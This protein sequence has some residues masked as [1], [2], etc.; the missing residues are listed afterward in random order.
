LTF[1]FGLFNVVVLFQALPYSEN[2]F[3]LPADA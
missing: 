2:S 3:H 1:W